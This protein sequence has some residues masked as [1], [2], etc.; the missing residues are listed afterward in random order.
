MS[1]VSLLLAFGFGNLLMLGWLAAAAAPILI[2]LWNKRKYREV[3]WAAVEYLLAAM[4]KNSRRMRLEQWLLLAV[5]TLIIV[6]LVFAVAQPFLEQAGFQFVPGGRTLKVLVLDGSY[7]MAYKPTD[8]SCF[9]RARQL[10]AQIV[11]ESAQGDAFALVLMAAP[12]VV[13]VGTPAV[14][15]GDFVDEVENLKLPHGSADLPATLLQV[16][17]ILNAADNDDWARREVYFLTDLGRNT[18]VPDLKDADAAQY[19]QRLTALSQRAALVVVDLGQGGAENLAATG[20]AAEDPYA[21]TAREVSFA[22]QIRNFGAQPKPHHLVEFHVDG[23]R[24]KESYVDVPAGEQASVAFSHRFDTPGDHVVELRAGPDLLDID[25]HRWLS[26]SVK[27]RLRVLCVNGKPAAG[28]MTGATDYLALA[29]NPET[30]QGDAPSV[31]EPEVI[32]ESALL[33]RD[34]SRYDCIFLCNVAQFTASEARV[35][36]GVLARGGGLVFFLGDQV[37]ADRYNRELAGEQ[38]VRVLPARVGDII[39]EAQYQY[40]DPLGYRHPLVRVFAGREQSGL[41]TTPVYKYFRLVVEPSSRARVALA[42]DDGDPAI[43]EETIQAGRCILVATDG[44]LSSVDPQT[45]QH[46]TTMPVWP[47]YVP[48]VQEILALAVGGQMNERNL[49]VGQQLGDALPAMA[50]RATVG[51]TNPSGDREDVR[52]VLDAQVSRWSYADTQQS[53]VYRAELGPPLAR[54]LSFAVNVDTNE[55]DLSRLAADDLPSEFLTHKRDDLDAADSPAIGQRSGLHRLLL[56]GVLGLLLFEMLL[57]G[58]F[59]GARS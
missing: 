18:W 35:L 27:D 33:E 5:R 29:L 4:R 20:L 47:S 41:L 14:E 34:L 11:D 44:S 46:W 53:G 54:E 57:A 17:Q 1:T 55:S 42:F 9:D 45:N 36:E 30:G 7:S 51:V 21:T 26:V 50:T 13:I 10:A 37:L 15:P 56:Y 49:Q 16:E 32:L 58:R 24:V 28:R 25:N 38:G 2:H 19:R 59:A 40:F 48:V 3:P 39:S 8:K 43:V 22:A 6:L 23:R 52:M 12:P 31:V